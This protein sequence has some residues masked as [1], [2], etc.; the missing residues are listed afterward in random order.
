MLLVRFAAFS[1]VYLTVLKFELV[2][3]IPLNP[4]NFG[5]C[6]GLLALRLGNLLVVKSYFTLFIIFFNISA[7]KF[8]TKHHINVFGS[9]YEG[10]LG[11]YHDVLLGVKFDKVETNVPIFH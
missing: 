2:A 6:H 5:G 11:I 8:K 3:F 9:H 10:L 4:K 7:F 1:L